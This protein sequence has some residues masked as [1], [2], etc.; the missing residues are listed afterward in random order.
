MTSTTAEIRLIA[1]T[2]TLGYGFSVDDFTR[3]LDEHRPHVIA[4]DA[5]STDPGPYYLGAGESFTERIENRKELEILIGAALALGIPLI[6]GTAGGCGARAHVNW[7]REIVEELA[8]EHA[9]SFRLAVI[10]SELS[11]QVVQEKLAAGAIVPF[12]TGEELTA[13]AVA[14]SAR[15]VAQMGL[16]PIAEALRQGSNV[17]LAGRSCDD[18]IFAALPVLQGFDRGLALHLGKILECG[19]LAAEPISMDVMLGTLRADHFELAPG[20]LQRA[21]TVT[22]VS[23]HSLYEREDPFTQSGP[24]GALDLTR[25]RVEQIDERRVRVRGTRYTEHDRYF[26][27]LEGARRIGERAISIAGVRCP[28]MIARIDAVLGEARRRTERYFEDVGVHETD[29][30]LEFHAYG[31]DAVMKELEPNRLGAAHE[32]GLVIEA[33]ADT[34]EL[35]KTVCHHV[36]GALLHLDYPGQ[37]NNAGNLAFLY[38]PSE[39]VVGDVYEFSVYHLME[40]DDPLEPV[41]IE[42]VDVGCAYAGDR[43]QDRVLSAR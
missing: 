31:R 39:I 34:A 37:F 36:A 33:V 41:Q 42:L 17:I 5:G 19:A 14:A 13:D 25:T 40:V 20:S 23:A 7:T 18:A 27:K 1:P 24:G 28:T 15:I 32:L 29:Y 8:R 43:R 16:E 11:T 35:A 38:S 10:Q 21:C 4:V 22:S 2:G 12:D 9:W 3:V 26:V 6:V 30:R